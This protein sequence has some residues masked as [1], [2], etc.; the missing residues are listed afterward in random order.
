M[1]KCLFLGEGHNIGIGGAFDDNITSGSGRDIVAG[2]SV[3]IE[4]NTTDGPATTMKS[5]DASIGG[6]D[7]MHLG[8]GVDP[9]WRSF[10]P[11]RLL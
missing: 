8:D 7:I 6:Y 2:D 10:F 9:L 5:K 11:V 1:P 4:F 3:V